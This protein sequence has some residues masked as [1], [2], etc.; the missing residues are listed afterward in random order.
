LHK[1]SVS[2]AGISSGGFLLVV[3]GVFR[4]SAGSRQMRK[5]EGGNARPKRWPARNHGRF[6]RQLL[7]ATQ[8][9]LKH[10][11]Y[12]HIKQVTAKCRECNQNRIAIF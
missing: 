12:C 6:R 1:L 2:A 4:A 8:R 3:L 7:L 11:F 10:D 5:Q 9:R